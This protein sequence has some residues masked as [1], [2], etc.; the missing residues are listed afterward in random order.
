MVP[1]HCVLIGRMCLRGSHSS[2]QTR[3]RLH[4]LLLGVQRIATKAAGRTSQMGGCLP[5]Q[6][7][8]LTVSDQAHGSKCSAPEGVDITHVSY[9]CS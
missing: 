4:C 3:R 6:K 8:S 7:V 5:R 2:V 1:M 9:A